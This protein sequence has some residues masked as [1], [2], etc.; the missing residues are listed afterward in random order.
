MEMTQQKVVLIISDLKKVASTV[1][2]KVGSKSTGKFKAPKHVTCG[3]SGTASRSSVMTFGRILI[4]VLK[5]P[6][7][8]NINLDLHFIS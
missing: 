4:L 7:Q 5:F 8:Q 1:R 6:Y 3:G 2:L